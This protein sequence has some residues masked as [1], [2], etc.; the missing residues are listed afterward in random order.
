VLPSG[1]CLDPTVPGLTGI[2]TVNDIATISLQSANNTQA[3]CINTAIGTIT[4]QVGGG[5]TGVT[6]TGLPPGVSYVF[7]PGNPFSTVT[8]SGSPTSTAGSP[9]NYTIGTVS[10]C[11]NPP[12][13]TG[14]ITV[15]PDATIGLTSAPA[16]TTQTKCI[17]NGI[18]PITYAI[19]GTVTSVVVNNLPPGVTYVYT[20]GAPGNLTVSGTPTSTAGSPYNYSVTIAGPCQLPAIQSGTITVTPDATISL[21]S[22]SSTPTTC[23]N[24]S[25]NNIVYQIFGAVTAVNVTGLPAGV[26][27]VY[28]PGNPGILTIAGTPTAVGPAAYSIAITGPCQVPPVTGGIITVTADATLTLNSGAA[29]LNQAV[30][31]NNNIVPIQY[32]VGGSATGGN[33]TFTPGPGLP[34]G[35]SLAVVGNTYTITGAP[36]VV[37]LTPVN[38]SF[39]FGTNGPCLNQQGTGT[40]TVNPNH[41]LTLNTAAATE[42]QT[43]CFN[44]AMAP[45]T[46]TYDGG[47]TG[48]TV[49]GLPAAGLAYTITGNVVTITGAPT[50]TVTYTIKTTGNACQFAQ[51]GGTITMVPLPTANFSFTAPSCNTRAI[52]FNDSSVPNSGTLSGWTW[53]FGDASPPG[54]GQNPTHTYANPGSYNVTLTVTTAPNGCAKAITL[55]VVINERPKTDFTFPATAVCINDMVLFTD[56]STLPLTNA[57]FNANGY[58][59]DFGDVINNTQNTKNGSHL[60]SAGGVYTVTHISES[61]A[62]CKDTITHTINIA[63]APVADFAVS[64]NAPLCVNDTVSIVNLSTIGVGTISKVEVYWDYLN[65]P[66][67]FDVYNSPVINAVY[68]HKYLNFQ[69]PGSKPYTVLVR[70]YSGISCTN[71]KLR[72]IAINAV[73]KV[74]FNAMPDVCYNATPFQITQASEVGGVAGSGVYSG[75]GVGA[76]GIFDPVTAGIGTH[77]IKYTYT[78]VAGCVDTMS[79]TIKVLDTASAKFTYVTAVCDGSPIIFNEASTTPAGVT[80]NNTIWNFG[81][82]SPAEQ[83]LPGSTFT[84]SFPTWGNYT[85]T[86]FNTS[87]Y[88]CKSTNNVTTLRV[89]PKPSAVFNFTQ[90]SVCLPNAPVS[91]V[92]TSAIA[93]NSAITY[94]W[95]FGDGPGPLSSSTAKN[96]PPHIY[97]GT[98]PYMVTLTVKGAVGTNGACLQKVTHL[99]DFIHPQPKAAFDFSKPEV[100]IGGDVIVTDRT[101]GLD[102]T[103]QQWYWNFDDGIK[104]NTPQVQ[105][106]YIAA[107]TYN[108]SLYIINSQ[109]CNS[110]TLTQP[111]TVHPFPVVDAG[112]DRVVLEGGSVTM[113]PV[114]TGNDLQYLW[115]PA[116][117]LNNTNTATP[118]ANIIMDD[119][120]YTLTVT[121]RGGC[122]APSDKVFI[123]VL[124]APRIPNTFTPNGDGINETWLIDYLDTYPNC[125]VQ[126]FTRTGQLVF[127]SR[128]YKTPWNGTIGGKPLPFDTYYYVIEPGNGRAPMTG[129]V[130]IIK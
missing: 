92:N 109:G 36:T 8:I 81:D 79:N 1:P 2:I 30:C 74:Q 33:F 39:S 19:D 104:A 85:I 20:P 65:A 127:E 9:Y 46:Y 107:N 35:L 58:K 90:T 111:F 14:I 5:A 89:N 98:G 12:P 55:P 94:A 40:I 49:T 42:N 32:T 17:N 106:L 119:I 68:K 71:D 91:V 27:A 18:N 97:T 123:K 96:P 3:P 54:N 13:L 113:Q 120:T 75:Q 44:S 26:T 102:G 100:C 34:A 53:N 83:H 67:T 56:A 60:F 25:I 43:V 51:R 57:P 61:A 86:M 66:G 7:T 31:V 41:T 45:I 69:T 47:A 62:G 126:V 73:P 88:G 59:W 6:V 15:R 114:V 117:Y 118:T 22:G 64:G 122:T 48:V 16:T 78:S 82:G 28:V 121:G 76:T 80:L 87:A 70:A 95:D 110:D 115:S 10:N 112:P 125:K 50:A 116:T 52:G 108:V 124:K 84:H 38:Y 21:F 29:S 23:V 130:T 105:H 129:Y 93:D 103:V 11:T 101:N 77:T 128:G 24:T 4:Y 99:V 63:S 37:S 72:V